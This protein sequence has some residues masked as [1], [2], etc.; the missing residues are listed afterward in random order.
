MAKSAEKG[1][2]DTAEGR[3]SGPAQSRPASLV[4]RSHIQWFREARF[5]MFVHFGPFSQWF[6]KE[7]RNSTAKRGEMSAEEFDRKYVAGLTPKKGCTRDW[8][9]LAKKAGMKYMV[10]TAKHHDAF[11]LWDSKLTDFNSVKLGPKR[12][13]VAE[14]VKAC[15]EQGLKVGLYYS[16]MD[17]HHPDGRRCADDEAARQRFLEY[18]RGL[19]RELM[20]NYG[21][22][23]MLWYDGPSPLGYAGEWESDKMNR[24]VRELQ[25]GIVI[26]DRALLAEDFS[27]PEGHISPTLFPDR[28]WEACMTFNGVWAWCPK[29]PEE[30]LTARQIIDMLH[31][32]SAGTGNLL[33][34]VGP[35]PEDARIGQTEIERLETVG[36]WLERHGEAAYGH[37][38]R[39]GGLGYTKNEIGAKWTR[40][41]NTA[42]LWLPDWPSGDVVIENVKAE[43]KTSSLL[44]SGEPLPFEQKDRRLTIRGLPKECPDPICGYAVLKL[45]FASYPR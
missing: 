27:C 35:R 37:L 23:D 2:S 31:Q 38:D 5:G 26:N 40:R 10:F 28:D 41:G 3:P 39:V 8:A 21:R 44:A 15:R 24:M 17:G 19:L 1:P 42:Y 33:L 30:Y 25:P 34:N 36:R 14:F 16:L 32:V 9:Q 43:L 22:I 18:T 45:E 12:D 11:C 20:T 6:H 7:W 4:D 29:P 13:M